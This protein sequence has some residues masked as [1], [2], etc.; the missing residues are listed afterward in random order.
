MSQRGRAPRPSA[1]GSVDPRPSSS[2]WAPCPRRAAQSAGAGGAGHAGSP[3][4]RRR[5]RRRRNRHCRHSRHSVSQG[6]APLTRGDEIPGLGTGVRVSVRG[7][8]DGGAVP[9]QYLPIGWGRHV[10]GTDAA[11]LAAALYTGAAHAPLR[12]PRLQ[13]RPAAR[14]ATA[15]AAARTPLQV[16]AGPRAPGRRPR[17]PS[18][19]ALAEGGGL[20]GGTG[21]W[22]RGRAQAGPPYP[23]APP[24]LSQECDRILG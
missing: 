2:A 8:D 11:F 1:A 4:G 6:C 20:P 3:S 21:G 15:P 23:L 12:A 16:R 7:R 10:A 18:S 9:E 13:P 19:P 17:P 22:T 5:R 14:A 24:F